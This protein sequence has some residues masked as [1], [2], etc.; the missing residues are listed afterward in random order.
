M[1]AR[2]PRA[3]SGG[4][5]GAEK[6]SGKG[7]LGCFAAQYFAFVFVDEVLA[8]VFSAG[9]DLAECGETGSRSCVGVNIDNLAALYVL[10]KSHCRVP[11]VVLHHVAV[12]LSL[13]HVESRVLED[14]S[15][16]VGA[17]GRVVQEVLAHRGKVLT[18]QALLL[19]ELVLAMSEPTALLLLTVF[20]V[21]P[22]EP[23]AAQL[24]LYFLLPAVLHLA[25]L[26]DGRERG[27]LADG[28]RVRLRVLLI[29]NWRCI[30]G[31]AARHFEVVTVR[32]EVVAA[33]GRKGRALSD[34]VV[35]ALLHLLEGQSGHLLL[36]STKGDRR[37]KVSLRTSLASLCQRRD[38]VLDGGGGGSGVHRG[39][40]LERV[41]ALLRGVTK[42]HMVLHHLGGVL[43][44]TTGGESLEP[45]SAHLLSWLVLL[46]AIVQ[47]RIDGHVVDGV[48]GGEGVSGAGAVRHV[49]S[50][51][52]PLHLGRE[53]VSAVEVGARDKGL[54]I[55]R[56][57]IEG[58]HRP[59]RKA[60]NKLFINSS[61]ISLLNGLHL[62]N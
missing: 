22:V 38:V 61:R 16:P 43:Q 31:H 24:G 7:R 53:V 2:A 41:P 47:P 33:L 29:H 59:S 1:S 32:G 14:T 42:I 52:G 46:H 4:R 51:V 10:E 21:L 57:G 18:A 35:V 54:A 58:S 62:R 49:V 28:R 37:E 39:L 55:C 9:A 17:L 34:S 45:T 12:V 27:V 36:V 3:C 26:R 13:A 6:V 30:E 15:L 8:V 25:W 20:T 23:E 56:E 44:S 40:G 11:R 5:H 50:L 60:F 19:L 48:L